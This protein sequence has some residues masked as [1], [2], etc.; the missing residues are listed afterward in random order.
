MRLK[1]RRWEDFIE[2]VRIASESYRDYTGGASPF[3]FYYIDKDPP[4]DED[5]KAWIEI[6]VAF[7]FYEQ[8]LV[9]SWNDFVHNPEER[10]EQVKDV[11]KTTLVFSGG[12]TI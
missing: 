6:D 2:Q 4:V 8:P 1:F 5:G 3:V 9:L 10:V 12:V 7:P 11:A